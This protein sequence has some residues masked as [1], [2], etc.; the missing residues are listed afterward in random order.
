MASNF[1]YKGSE[2][3][4]GGLCA[5]ERIKGGVFVKPNLFV[6]GA[7]KSG[8]TSLHHVLGSHPEIYM[9]EP[10]EPAFFVPELKYLPKE[11]DWY[12][13]LFENCGDVKYAG[14]SSTHYAKRPLFEGVYERIFEF[15]PEARIIYLMRDPLDRAISHYWHNIHSIRPEFH[16][17]RPMLEAISE[18]PL[19]MEYGNYAMQL[20][21][22]LERFGRDSILPVVYEE[23]I[24]DP[25]AEIERIFNWLGVSPVDAPQ[26]LEHKNARQEHVMKPRGL[27]V[28]ESFRHSRTWNYLAPWVPRS[29]KRIASGL[30]VK[31]EKPKQED[32]SAAVMERMRPIAKVNVERIR[33]LLGRDFPIWKSTLGD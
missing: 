29:L 27:G 22:W 25:S 11:Q 16:E 24:A 3:L 6:I 17:E 12:I 20:E 30:A 1:G 4:Y 26:S 28:L 21:P 10:K 33:E 31:P 19:Y 23:L 18:D 13:S 32:M 9:C 14:E 15:Q 5:G 2:A 8:T 7:A